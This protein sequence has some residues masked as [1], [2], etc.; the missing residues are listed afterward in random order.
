MRAPTPYLIDVSHYASE[1]LWLSYAA[2]DISVGCQ[3]L[4]ESQGR[5][6][7]VQFRVSKR[8]TDPWDAVLV[9]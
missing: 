3:A 7:S 4:I 6:G 5:S 8:V 9:P 1:S 2:E